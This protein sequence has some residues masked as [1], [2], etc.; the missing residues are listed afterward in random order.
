MGERTTV[1]TTCALCG[2]IHHTDV[3]AAALVRWR[4][5]DFIQD[6]F[7]H[8]SED[9]REILLTG[10][11]G[12]CWDAA[13]AE[14]DDEDDDCWRCHGEGGWHDCGDDTCCCLDPEDPDS[15]DWG[16]CPECDGTGRHRRHYDAPTTESAQPDSP[17]PGARREP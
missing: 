13:F 9:A 11:C 8:L 3:D 12:P 17:S 15:D 2:R 1:V 6:A 16:A 10:T 5:G 4:G 7:P 14:P